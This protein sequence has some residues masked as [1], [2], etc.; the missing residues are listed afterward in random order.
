[1]QIRAGKT[2]PCFFLIVGIDT[3]ITIYKMIMAVIQGSQAL[4]E[5]DMP[6]LNLNIRTGHYGIVVNMPAVFR[7]ITGH[8]MYMPS[9]IRISCGGSGV[10]MNMPGSFSGPAVEVMLVQL[11]IHCKHPLLLI[12][13]EA[14]L[15][16]MRDTDKYSYISDFEH[17]SAYIQLEKE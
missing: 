8:I 14:V 3:G 12:Y 7:G 11:V 13:A 10:F 1:V 9:K 5:M 15:L 16:D 17:K 4:I 6:L 2:L